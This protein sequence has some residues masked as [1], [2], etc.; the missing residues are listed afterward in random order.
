MTSELIFNHFYRIKDMPFRGKPPYPLV[1]DLTEEELEFLNC[2][3]DHY[4]AGPTLDGKSGVGQIIGYL[5]E[6]KEQQ[7]SGVTSLV[8]PS[9]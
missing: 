6:F 3:L 9:F 1:K 5:K 8:L 2:W 4:L 7:D